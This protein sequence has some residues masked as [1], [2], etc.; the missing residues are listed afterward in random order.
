MPVVPEP[1]DVE[2]L[3]T[4]IEL[5]TEVLAGLRI[6]EA[7][8]KGLVYSLDELNAANRELI[9]QVLGT[10]E[11][12]IRYED[13][14]DVVVQEA[15]LAGVWRVQYMDS[16][17]C[18]AARR[19][20]DRR[21]TGP[22]QTR[23]VRGRPEARRGCRRRDTAWPCG[24]AAALISEINDK[25]P[26]AGPGSEPHVINLTL[27]PR[28]RRRHGI[29]HRVAGAAAPVVILSRGYGNCRITSTGTRYTWWV[30]YFN[31]QDTAD[32]E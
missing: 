28:E 11:V 6:Y 22:G 1:E 16:N 2:G 3:D 17:G 24:N 18:A 19:H 13:E 25:L 9:N 27:L 26:Q 31:S 30:Q 29:S 14:L 4:G 20:R 32:T 5:L 21:H 23:H 8:S 7:G 15:V 10:G 12:S